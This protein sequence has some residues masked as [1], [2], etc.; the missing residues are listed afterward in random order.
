MLYSTR[1]SVTDKEEES[2]SLLQKHKVSLYLY[3]KGC[4]IR[5]K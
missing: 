4:V 1:G 5:E 3:V 2:R